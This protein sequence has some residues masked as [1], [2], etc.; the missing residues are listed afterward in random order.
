MQATEGVSNVKV[1]ISEGAAT[2]EVIFSTTR[3]D[4]KPYLRWPLIGGC[5]QSVS[6]LIA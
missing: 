3:V 2:V 4:E 6:H 1:Y 5:S